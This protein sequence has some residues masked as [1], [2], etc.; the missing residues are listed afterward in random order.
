MAGDRGV[1]AR[2]R[3]VRKVRVGAVRAMAEAL[4][5]AAPERERQHLPKLRDL[6]RMIC[7]WEAG[8]H[9]VSERLLY[10]RVLKMTRR[11]CFAGNVVWS[12]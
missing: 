3:A 10:C 9:A 2:M 12:P 8:E 5:E 7:G 1:G 6:C 4:W 11:T